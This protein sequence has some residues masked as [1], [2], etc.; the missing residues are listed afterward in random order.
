VILADARGVIVVLGGGPGETTRARAHAAALLAN[1]RPD[2]AVIASGGHGL[3]R[4]AS[5]RTE[6]ELMRETLLAYGIDESR[7]LL[8]DESRDTIGNALFT[9]LRYLAGIPPRPLVVVTSPS[10]LARALEVFTYVLPG[11]PLEAHAS[12]R[13]GSESDA[14]EERLREETRAFFAGIRRGDVAAI[15]R[16]LRQRWPEYAASERLTS[17]A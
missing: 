3:A 5:G 9:T 14:R 15:A 11:W 8:E 1:A 2:F 17:F 4:E 6:A 7:V 13:L 16:R 12:A 10:H